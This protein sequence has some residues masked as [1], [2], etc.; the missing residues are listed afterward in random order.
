VEPRGALSYFQLHAEE[1]EGTV[2]VSTSGTFGREQVRLL[3]Q[4][5]ARLPS[6]ATVVGAVDADEAG[7]RMAAQLEALAAAHPG[8]SFERH[9]PKLGKDWN[10]VLQRTEREF[11]R[12]LPR[13]VQALGLARDR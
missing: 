2:Y 13:E 3:G 10:D 5:M 6:G 9:V 12:S 8:L 4:A 7:T 11:I 1:R